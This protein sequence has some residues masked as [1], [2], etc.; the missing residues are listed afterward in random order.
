MYVPTT[1]A[2]VFW[3]CIFH[4]AFFSQITTAYFTLYKEEVQYVT[5]KFFLGTKSF[6]QKFTV[7]QLCHCPEFPL[8]A[9]N[10]TAYN[11]I[12]FLNQST[13]DKDNTYILKSET[14]NQF[15]RITVF[16]DMRSERVCIHIIW[17]QTSPINIYYRQ[18]TT[19][20][21]SNDYH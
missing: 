9:E 11:L 20:K 3:K 4:A 19:I 16:S 5:L 6:L 10:W 18:N 14:L 21:L 12:T 7:L 15:W 17:R 13:Y 2:T 1:L 8:A